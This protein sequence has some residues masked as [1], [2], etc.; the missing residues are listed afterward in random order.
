MPENE[1]KI[2]QIFKDGQG[3]E[4][5]LTLNVGIIEDV[6]EKTDV[7]FDMLI[8]N[9]EDMSALLIKK[10]AKLGQILWVICEDQCKVRNLDPRQF[11]KRLTRDT[12]DHA[13]NSLMAAVILFYQRGSAGRALAENLPRIIGEMDAAIEKSTKAKIHTVSSS[14]AT[15]LEGLSDSTVPKSEQPILDT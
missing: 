15:A 6:K 11:G 10:P 8:E 7:D 13:V 5:D 3:N 14:I 9:A 4:W 1:Q 12:I 2:S